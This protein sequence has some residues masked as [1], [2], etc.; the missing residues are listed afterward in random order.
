MDSEVISLCGFWIEIYKGMGS[1]WL[2]NTKENV[3]TWFFAF[4]AAKMIEIA[5]F[6]FT[7]QFV[8]SMR[9]FWYPY[10]FHFMSYGMYQKMS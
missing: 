1:K 10:L 3:F 6:V 2:K 4:Y 5:G 7:D 9:F 8:C